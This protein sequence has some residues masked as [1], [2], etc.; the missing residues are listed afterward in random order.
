[1][2]NK[3][4]A[5]KL[6]LQKI[7]GCIFLLTLPVTLQ[8][9]IASK[10][11]KQPHYHCVTLKKGKSF[12][13]LSPNEEDRKL[14]LKLNRTNREPGYGMKIAVPNDLKYLNMFDISP[15]PSNIAATG[16]KVIVVDPK[17]LAFGAYTSDGELRYWGPISAG[18]NWCKDIDSECRTVT[19][20]FRIVVKRGEDCVSTKFPVDVGGA[21]MPYCMFFHDGYAL[22]GSNSVPGYNA[23][24][25]CVRLTVEDAQWLNEE[26]ADIGTQVIIKP[27]E[28]ES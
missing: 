4:T 20:T 25:G 22:H 2:D 8:A 11:C 1:M 28:D 13:K 18:R 23:S 17:E 14:I 5:T 24:H 19:G 16:K 21:P 7:I 26:F 27:Y 9:G 10:Y 3:N 15:M 6:L 12:R